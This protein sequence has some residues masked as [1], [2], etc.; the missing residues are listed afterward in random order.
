[1][2]ESYIPEGEPTMHTWTFDVQD[3][4]NAIS[5]STPLAERLDSIAYL[6][7]YVRQ[8]VLPGGTSPVASIPRL[9]PE[10][11]AVGE[12]ELQALAA[13]T[14]LATRSVDV[15]AKAADAIDWVSVLTFLVNLAQ[16]LLPLVKS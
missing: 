5:P 1:V 15:T 3:A 13:G 16:Q 11:H 10:L 7:G 12:K 8:E 2:K 14:K 4:K 9:R 6:L